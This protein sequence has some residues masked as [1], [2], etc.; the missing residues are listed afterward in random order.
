MRSKKAG[1]APGT[2]VH[3]GERLTEKVKISV[4]AYDEARLIER[5]VTDVAELASFRESYA[6][7][8]INV[9]GLHDVDIIEQIGELFH[10]HPLIMEDIL[11]TTQRPKAEDLEDYL[12]IVFRALEFD[13]KASEIHSDQVSLIVGTNFLIS[14]Q[15]RGT[16]LFDAIRTRIRVGKGRI[17]KSGPDYLAYSLL[18]AIV[19]NYFVILEKL[20]EQIEL[21]EEELV[22]NPK[23]ET[24]TVIHRMKIHMIFMRKSVWPLREVINRLLDGE[25]HLIEQPTMPYLRDVYDHTIH[26]IDTMETS[27]DIISGMLDIYLSS[28]SYRL[29]EIMKVLTIIATIFIPLTFLAGWYG[30]NFKT[31]P[32][33]EW[34]YGYVMVICMAI[35]IVA[36]M[37]IYFKRKHWW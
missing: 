30:M 32:E 7:T 26:A 2:L 13:E 12:F 11:N 5:E 33:F 18:D 10:L 1:L 19:D 25:S 29:N 15:E 23:P 21:L 3:V 14:F 37:L 24:L 4:M 20:G 27:R 8:W 34:R 6:V 9:D 22:T 36:I 16:S 28:V 17:R 31:I 35:S